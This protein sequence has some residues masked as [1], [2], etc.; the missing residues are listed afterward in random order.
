M[1]T[2]LVLC[3]E[4]QIVAVIYDEDGNI[5]DMAYAWQAAQ[6]YANDGYYVQA[7]N[8]DIS[9]FTGEPMLTVDEAQDLYDAELR[10]ALDC[11]G[12]GHRK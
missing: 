11:F 3:A 6:V 10:W 9:R 2:Q 7:V 4:P 1:T 5:H 12:E 8:D